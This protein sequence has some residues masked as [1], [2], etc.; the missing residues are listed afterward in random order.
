MDCF[1]RDRCAA[2]LYG[3]EIPFADYLHKRRENIFPFFSVLTATSFAKD[4][5][6]NGSSGFSSSQVSFDVLATPKLPLSD[7]RPTSKLVLV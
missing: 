4:S 7:V 1:I 3:K 2:P 5:L 6:R